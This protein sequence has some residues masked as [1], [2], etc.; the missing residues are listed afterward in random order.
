MPKERPEPQSVE[1]AWKE[2]ET[3]LEEGDPEAGLKSLRSVWKADKKDADVGRTWAIAGDLK[4]ALAEK[5]EGN[6]RKKHYRAALDHYD[7]SLNKEPNKEV[8][9]R[10]NQ[11]HASMDELGI[12]RGGF[13][14]ID[15]GA[16]TV[17]GLGAI[18]VSAMLFLVSL[19]YYPDA[20]AFARSGEIEGEPQAKFTI[21][22]QTNAGDPSSRRS[23]TIWVDLDESA[24]PLTV[25]N[26]V[27]LSEQGEFNDTIFH[28]IIADFMIQGGDFENR[29]GTGGY[30]AKWYGFCNGQAREDSSQCTRENWAL[31]DEASNGLG[32]DPCV[33]AMANSGD[34]TTGAAQFYILPE[35][36]KNAQTNEPGPHWLDGK[37]TVFGKVSDGCQHITAIG[38]VQTD[39]ND[40]PLSDVILTSVEIIN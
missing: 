16:P 6:L 20:L 22:Y 31:P 23:A 3:H 13:R 14:L 29:D 32:H 26:F 18:V 38:D 28:R 12:T 39:T 36:A 4:T 8:R 33:I 25:E 40:R 1:E 30:T 27:M 5:S 35:D 34:P 37:H 7:Q 17:W 19:K 9:R 15:D 21:S 11:V 24:A 10:M 2:A